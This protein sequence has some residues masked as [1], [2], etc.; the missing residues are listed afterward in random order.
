ML[1]ML[2][3]PQ[4]R[5]S[6]EQPLQPACKGCLA[7]QQGPHW[8]R[9]PLLLLELRALQQ[10]VQQQWRSLPPPPLLL[11]CRAGPAAVVPACSSPSA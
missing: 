7:L 8:L 9:R 5:W 6:W 1:V 11:R 4:P 2:L 3:L 10:Q